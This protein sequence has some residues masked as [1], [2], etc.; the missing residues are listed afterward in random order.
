[1]GVTGSVLVPA[2]RTKN[3]PLGFGWGVL[4]GVSGAGLVR[5]KDQRC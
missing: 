2:V 5:E 1:M 3:G 4:A